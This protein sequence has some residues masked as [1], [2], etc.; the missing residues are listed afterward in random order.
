[1]SF[2]I[3]LPKNLTEVLNKSKYKF[4]VSPKEDPKDPFIQFKYEGKIYL[5]YALGLQMYDILVMRLTDN[6]EVYYGSESKDKMILTTARKFDEDF[7]LLIRQYKI[8]KRNSKFLRILIKFIKLVCNKN[9][10][11]P[12]WINAIFKCKDKYKTKDQLWNTDDEEPY[13]SN[14]VAKITDTQL[15]KKY[16]DVREWYNDWIK[17]KEDS[18][19]YCC[20]V[21]EDNGETWTIF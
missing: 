19:K 21:S 10:S 4:D 14:P 3:N 12:K 1:M 8:S 6:L 2:S 13:L 15:K 11:E 18:W 7:S 17:D 5:A 20:G 9:Y 16:K